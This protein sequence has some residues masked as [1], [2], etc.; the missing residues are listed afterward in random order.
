MPGYWNRPATGQQEKQ[1]PRS[2][3]GDYGRRE[4]GGGGGGG[5]DEQ[6]RQ[7]SQQA[8]LDRIRREGEEKNKNHEVGVVIMDN[9]K[10]VLRIKAVVAV[11]MNSDDKPA[12]RPIWIESRER[13]RQEM[14]RK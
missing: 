2:W 6:R 8:N 14:R 3:S 1:E 11:E 9:E 4:E 12:S 10:T 7:A 5:G 13:L